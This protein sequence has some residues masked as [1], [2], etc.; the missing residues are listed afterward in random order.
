MGE[1]VF[2]VLLSGVAVVYL[3]EA[4]GYPMPKFEVSGG[5]AIYPKMILIIFLILVFVRLIQIITTKE[6]VKFV[7]IDLF[8]GTRGV[9]WISFLIYA[10]TVKTIGY[11]I[12]TI[13]FLIGMTEYFYYKKT[14]SFGTIRQIG[15]RTIGLIGFV[16]LLYWFF[17]VTMNVLLPKGVLSG[18]L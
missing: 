5:P 3:V 18:V 13:V 11:L 17:A 4:F 9:F 14:N 16:V 10:L 6:K 7:F 1:I 12:A 8:T 2:L 15:L